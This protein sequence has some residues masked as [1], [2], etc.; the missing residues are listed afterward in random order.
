MF[1]NSL[2]LLHNDIVKTQAKVFVG[3]IEG[4]G[5][6]VH[7]RKHVPSMFISKNDIVKPIDPSVTHIITDVADRSKL[8]SQLN[9]APID[10]SVHI[11][12]SCWLSDCAVHDKL[13]GTSD[14]KYQ[15]GVPQESVVSAGDSKRG[16]FVVVAGKSISV[17]VAPSVIPSHMLVSSIGKKRGITLTLGDNFDTPGKRAGERV[18]ESASRCV[19]VDHSSSSCLP[20]TSTALFSIAAES[21]GA[22]L[23]DGCWHLIDGDACMVRLSTGGVDAA[24]FTH[25]VAFDLDSTLIATK[26]GKVFSQNPSD[27]RL[28]YP[29]ATMRA[30]L[31]AMPF[32]DKAGAGVAAGSGSYRPYFMIISNQNGVEEGKTDVAS[33]QK[34]FDSVLDLLNG[35]LP[36]GAAFDII[37][38]FRDD[39]YRKPR[40]LAWNWMVN[41]RGLHH[42]P[43]TRCLYVGDAAGRLK[44]GTRKADFSSA[45]YKFALN[46]KV[47][48]QTPE[49]FFLGDKSALH[50]PQRVE[51]TRETTTSPTTSQTP[52]TGFIRLIDMFACPTNAVALQAAADVPT[53]EGQEM[54]L[55]VAPVASGKSTF[56]RMK[57]FAGYTIVNQDTLKTV[58]RC[59]EAASA[60]LCAGRSVLVDNTNISVATRKGW[61]ALAHE[62][63]VPVRCICLQTSKQVCMILGLHRFL[64]PTT[65][66]A[67][68][69]KIQTVTYHTHFKYLEAP[70]AS[71]GFDSVLSLPLAIKNSPA[72]PLLE[73]YLD[74]DV[75]GKMSEVSSSAIAEK[76]VGASLSSDGDRGAAYVNDLLSYCLF[77]WYLK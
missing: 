24:G 70:D 47:G 13:M 15:A 3:L 10:S 5:G 66:V 68:R 41:A 65:S 55:L 42:V 61:I 75:E 22:M 74:R 32:E 51:P 27:F 29:G 28:L 11:L 6:K 46:L 21:G 36:E 76:A 56:A 59:R 25:I 62:R 7:V 57:Q 26:S 16:D 34:K 69:R 50:N 71:E 73:D 35:L 48:F 23:A 1:R 2:F 72:K 54:V 12:K 45:D 20:A 60:A 77:R 30:G 4:K 43:A 19:S 67:D 33:L 63:G 9:C 14:T 44:S 52:T 18:P 64:N 17:P 38:A 58:D 49:R 40:C 53:A 8:E 37:C 31:A 39:L